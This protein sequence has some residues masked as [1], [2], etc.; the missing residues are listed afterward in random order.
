MD[1]GRW[2]EEKEEQ[3]QETQLGLTKG[4]DHSRGNGIEKEGR[5]LRN[6]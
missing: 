5:G 2:V 3:K 1:P 6:C 4:Y